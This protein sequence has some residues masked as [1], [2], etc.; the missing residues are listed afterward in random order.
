MRQRLTS[1]FRETLTEHKEGIDKEGL[2]TEAQKEAYRNTASFNPENTHFKNHNRLVCKMLVYSG[3]R[4][5]EIAQLYCNDIQEK[6]A[7]WFIT[8]HTIRLK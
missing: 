2:L 6:G 1:L 4:L 3:A 7:L 5:N 8:K